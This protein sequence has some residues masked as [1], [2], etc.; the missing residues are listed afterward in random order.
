VDVPVY[1]RSFCNRYLR[2]HASIRSYKLTALSAWLFLSLHSNR[3][4]WGA[5]E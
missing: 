3:G 1:L 2:E 5:S 4:W